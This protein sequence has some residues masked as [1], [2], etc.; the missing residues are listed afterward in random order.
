MGAIVNAFQH[1]E[2]E[3]LH[4]YIFVLLHYCIII[5]VEPALD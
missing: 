5:C 2:D 3:L 4:Y 1:M